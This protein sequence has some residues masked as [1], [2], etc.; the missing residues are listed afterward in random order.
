MDID[1]DSI[2]AMSFGTS[3]MD[4]EEQRFN[5][6]CSRIA[7]NDPRTTQ[8]AFDNMG[9][10]DFLLT[11]TNEEWEQIGRD[12]SNNT[13]LEL[14]DCFGILSNNENGLE[15]FLR[16]LVGSTSIVDLG[17]ENNRISPA[18]VRSLVPFLQNSCKLAS[19][20]IG[21]NNIG[22]E[23]FNILLWALR[24]S[25]IE[26][27]YCGGSGIESIEIERGYFPRVLKKLDLS[28]NNISSDGCK[29]IAQLL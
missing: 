17:L 8:F 14:V 11:V 16:G 3:L 29:G 24:D 26:G 25:Q 13:H 6:D 23:G 2:A 12:V 9:G 10:V 5:T 21:R 4:R 7:D 19:L 27:L 18:G 1:E 15:S 22:S 20:G 28:R